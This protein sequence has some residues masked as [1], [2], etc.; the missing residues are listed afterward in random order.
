MSVGEYND[1]ILVALSCKPVIVFTN[2]YQGFQES[3]TT[4][5]E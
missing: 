3:G 5:Q 1:V 4:E 2:I